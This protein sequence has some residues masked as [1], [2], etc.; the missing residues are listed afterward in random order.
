MEKRRLIGL[1]NE[2][3]SLPSLESIRN[4]TDLSETYIFKKDYYKL[5]PEHFFA[6]NVNN[7]RGHCKKL[8]MPQSNLD[9]H[10]YFYTQREVEPWNK[11]PEEVECAQTVSSF[12]TNYIES[13]TDR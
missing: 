4:D 11:P 7:L 6:T 10:K 12:R 1:A 5:K 13:R 8:F 9:H 2:D 3:I